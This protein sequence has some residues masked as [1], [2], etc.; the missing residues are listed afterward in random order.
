MKTLCIYH[1]NCADGFGAAWIVRKALDEENVEFFAASYQQAPPPVAGRKVIIVDF[2]YK[3]E[4]MEQMAA[5]A[6]SIL[7]LDHHKTAEEDLAPLLESGTVVGRFDMKLSGVGL[8]WQHFFPN[9]RM[10]L[11]LEIIQD[12]DLWT[13]KHPLTKEVTAALFSYPYDF[14]VWESL[15]Y[16]IKD[17]QAEG[18]AILRKQA[19]DI[20]NIVQNGA[21]FAV[22][23]GHT[24]PV[25]NAPKIFASDSCHLLAQGH[26]FAACYVDGETHR[27]YSLRSSD[28]GLDVSEVARLFGGG[29]HKHAAGFSVEKELVHIVATASKEAEA[30]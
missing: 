24:V 28:D 21:Y 5:E 22:I 1:N 14:S 2:S 16:R 10:P 4:V 9:V 6:E 11:L 26:P 18:V 25:V 3:R 19:H 30:C 20:S 17:L 12:R 13:F 15:M 23:A 7:V 29:G 8:T 27:E